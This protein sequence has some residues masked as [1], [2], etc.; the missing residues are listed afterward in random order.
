MRRW[1]DVVELSLLLAIHFI[2]VEIV[3]GRKIFILLDCNKDK[4]YLNL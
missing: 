2:Q 1:M 3:I 4:G